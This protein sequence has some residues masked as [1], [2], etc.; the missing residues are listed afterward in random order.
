MIGKRLRALRDE[1][2]MMQSE[3]AAQI[4]VSPCMI[5]KYENDECSPIDENKVKL[6]QALNTTTDYLLGISDEMHP[7]PIYQIPQYLRDNE[8]DTFNEFI[9]YFQYK[10]NA[11]TKEMLNLW[12]KLSEKQQEKYL[13]RIKEDLAAKD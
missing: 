5:S 9:G 6:A 3:L 12:E 13:R 4:N 2:K 1:T 11:R 10:S 7:A 8:T